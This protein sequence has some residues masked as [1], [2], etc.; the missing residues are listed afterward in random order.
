MQ[1]WTVPYTAT[2]GHWQHFHCFLTPPSNFKAPAHVCPALRFASQSFESNK[3]PFLSDFLLLT[4]YCSHT[5]ILTPL[6]YGQSQ[7][8]LSTLH[9][10]VHNPNWPCD[11]ERANHIWCVFLWMTATTTKPHGCMVVHVMIWHDLA[12]IIHNR[13]T[14]HLLVSFT[15][16]FVLH[17]HAFNLMKIDTCAFFSAYWTIET[18]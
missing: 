4:A 1:Q 14:T 16:D 13:A 3:S 9:R 10:N 12:K 5:Q 8:N 18:K 2:L 17:N 6:P 11:W 7:H 15:W